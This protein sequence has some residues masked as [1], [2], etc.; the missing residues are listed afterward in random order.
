MRKILIFFII[1]ILVVL[2]KIFSNFNKT[3]N[4]E[5][6]TSAIFKH[7]K[8]SLLEQSLLGR[9]PKKELNR[10]DVLL[11]GIRGEDDKEGGFLT[12]SIFLASLNT[13]NNKVALISLPRD[14]YVF[15]PGLNRYDRLNSVYAWSLSRHGLKE[16]LAFTKEFFSRLTDV[17]VDHIVVVNI[18]GL[19]DLIDNLG[20]IT[21]NLEADFIE[22]KQWGCDIFGKNCL[23]FFLPK[24]QNTLDGETAL[25]YAR[26]RFSSSDFDRQR[27][28]LELLEA[29]AGKIKN[30]GVYKNPIQLFRLFDIIARNLKTDLSLREIK[31]YYERFKDSL[32]DLNSVKK[33]VIKEDN[34]IIRS[35]I[36]DGKYILVPQKDKFNIVRERI[37]KAI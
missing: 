30:E 8:T 10:I 9:A 17:F 5:A 1:V 6:K 37:K 20:G 2:F 19:K 31:S 36:L 34:E 32:T 18:D 28:I 12:D 27:R 14:L 16:G 35:T 22:D 21:V 33:I 15:I 4:I 11:L 26:S 25:I 23:V 29:I 13:T 3:I 7:I 24:G